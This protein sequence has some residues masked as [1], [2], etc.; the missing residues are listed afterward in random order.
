MT[1]GKDDNIDGLKNGDDFILSRPV[2][3]GRKHEPSDAVSDDRL[4]ASER[5]FAH[6]ASKGRLLV[7]RGTRSSNDWM[8]GRFRVC[9]VDEAGNI[10]AEH[11]TS[12]VNHT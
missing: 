4:R 6:V 11:L 12:R 1:S 10:Q 3:F 2:L 5:Q 7:V 8:K 9:A